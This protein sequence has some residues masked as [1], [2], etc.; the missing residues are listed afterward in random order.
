MGFYIRKSFGLGPLRLNLSKS[1]LGASVGV[2]GARVSFGP[3]GTVFHAGRGGL[4]FRQRL[5]TSGRSGRTPA[6]TPGSEP[7]AMKDIGAAPTHS[8]SQDF[9]LDELRRCHNRMASTPWAPAAGAVVVVL[10]VA[11]VV[12]LDPL[13]WA[14]VGLAACITIAAAFIAR[15][16]DRRRLVL[17]VSYELSERAGRIFG[18]L[19]GV[20]ARCEQ[21]DR[22]WALTSRGHTPDWKR[23]AGVNTIVNRSGAVL[24]MGFPRRLQT[25][26]QIFRLS[27][28]T[29]RIYFL[30]DRILFYAGR[31][32]HSFTYAEVV[33]ESAESQFV[34]NAKLPSDA[35]VVGNTW[36]YVNKDGG[37]DRRFSNNVQ[38]P[39]CLY[40]Q[41]RLATASG[42][43]AVIQTSKSDAP[44]QVVAA[45]QAMRLVEPSE[46]PDEDPT[47]TQV[48][49]QA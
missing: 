19:T 26:S 9:F 7:I 14:F 49:V 28:P 21:C 31:K 45:I 34:E 27:L 44:R 10:L 8:M 41:L 2:K 3:K 35:N 5:D 42:L 25:D 1:G 30:P 33:A 47:D 29:G 38:L 39:V 20:L 32:V 23:N 24:G 48:T 46:V 16:W 13:Y 18:G 12:P 4:Y 6:S 43:E 36:R 40:G 22:L 15:T 37:P 11:L 17:T